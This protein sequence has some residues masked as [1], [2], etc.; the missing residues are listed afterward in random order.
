MTDFA[1]FD[2]VAFGIFG[3]AWFLYHHFVE[4]PRAGE[5]S[6][7]G[8]MDRYRA[9]WI[10][11][12]EL[13]EERIFDTQV[14]A[15]LQNGT[16]FF[17]STSLFAFGGSFALIR[18]ADDVLKIFADLP[19]GIMTTRTMWEI[20]VTGLALIFVYAFFKFAW[21]YR[22]FN[23]AAILLGAAPPANHGTSTDRMRH[24]EALTA[25]ITDAGREFNR[26]QRAFFFAL[27]YVGWFV[28][29]IALIITT[30]AALIAMMQRQ[31]RSRAHAA[32]K[33]LAAYDETD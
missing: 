30:I 10:K 4:H 8:L 3:L 22:L 28:S 16:A 15:G 21:S 19:L 12:M 31:F 5:Q 17:A 1:L 27:A 29:P 24:A 23:Y 26:G 33:A 2:A 11:Q 25:V 7:N 6:L 14:L 18:A 32:I 20:K 13:R 9:R